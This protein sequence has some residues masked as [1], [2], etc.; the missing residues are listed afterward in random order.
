MAKAHISEYGGIIMTSNGVAPVVREPSLTTQAVTYTTA[1][2]SAA[3]G[4]NTKLIRIVCDADAYIA[5]GANPTADADS[6]FL[7]SG[8]VEYFG[9]APG[10]KVSIYDGT[11]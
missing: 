8:I 6:A 4:G 7:P 10:D 5:F 2:Q 3:F 1:T 9:V 11:S